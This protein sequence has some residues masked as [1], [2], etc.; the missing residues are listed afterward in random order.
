MQIEYAREQVAKSI[1]ADKNQ[2]FFTSGATESNNWICS[3]YDRIISSDIEHHSISECS[4][5]SSL[6]I[7]H[8]FD[9]GLRYTPSMATCMMVNNETGIIYPIKELC[10]LA[11]KHKMYF[12]TDAT[13][14]FGHILIDVKE[15]NVDS[16]SLSAHKFH[17]PKGIGIL[18][19]K[20]PNKYTSFIRGGAQEHNLRAGTENTASIIG[21]G[22]AC[23]LYNYNPE[24]DKLNYQKRDKFISEIKDIPD[25]LINTGLNN[26]I[27]TTINMSFKGIEGESLMLMLDRENIYVS[28]GSACNSG[29]LEPSRVLKAM[30]V[31]KDY[32]NGS[33]RVSFSNETTE[34]ELIIAA[35][36]I[37]RNIKK[38]RGY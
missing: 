5:V 9:I 21:M 8:M 23:E 32:I 14:A 15:L 17:V 11:H 6:P 16:L 35:E 36:A 28:S 3:Q 4:Y 18:Y 7:K 10:E 30:D 1:N 37:K 20:E 19:L 33:I 31:P 12:H 25:M 34:E 38:I 26:S 27:A 24:T 13:A 22:V 29:S 2:I